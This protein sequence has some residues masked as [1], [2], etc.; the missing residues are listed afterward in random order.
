MTSRAVTKDF[1]QFYTEWKQVAANAVY[2]AGFH[3]HEAED[4]VQD[5][6]TELYAGNYLEKYD[7]K[8]GAFSTYIWGHINVR[9]MGRKRDLWKRSQREFI[10]TPKYNSE[11]EEITFPDP[12]D[13]SE[14]GVFA[15]TELSMTVDAI[16]R[17]LDKLPATK[18]KN[19]ARLFRDIVKQVT[20][21]GE[22]SQTELAR[23]YGCSRQA[24]SYQV[25]DLARC[26]AVRQL[27]EFQ[28]V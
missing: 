12:V 15:D 3:D 1:T 25:A 14:L 2:R 8:R 20:E 17:E 19:L 10:P 24:I 6:F 28:L 9:I 22:F 4:L 5:I 18:S 11:G 13:E 7:A 16:C 26:D 27:K 23:K 21:N